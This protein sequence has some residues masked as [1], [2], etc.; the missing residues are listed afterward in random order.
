M[1]ISSAIVSG[2]I[3]GLFMAISVGPTLFAVLRYSLNHSYRAGIAFVLG[4][5]ISDIIY[6]TVA[7]VATPW[8][9]WLHQ[10][11]RTMYYSFAVLLM[12]AG[13]YGLFKKYK[14]ERPSPKMLNVSQAQ[15]MRIGLSGFLINTFNPALVIQWIA[16]ATGL[17]NQTGFYRLIFFT[18]CLGLVLGID[19]LKVLLADKIR[20]KLTIRRVMYLQKIS[21]GCIMAFGVALLLMTILNIE[22]KTPANTE[23]ASAEK[24]KTE[25]KTHS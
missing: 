11:E 8:L 10:Y 9:V 22:F 4:V 23:K 20:Q 21:A 12:L 24:S 18:C 17:A 5:S 6:V 14:P 19:V 3:L 1:H 15:Y 25:V 16:A 7:N 13:G 2:L